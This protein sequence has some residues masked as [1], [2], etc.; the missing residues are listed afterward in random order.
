MNNRKIETKKEG[1]KMKLTLLQPTG[2]KI[3]PL[4]GLCNGP[5]SDGGMTNLTEE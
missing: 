3:K 5:M 4:H 1:E 2:E